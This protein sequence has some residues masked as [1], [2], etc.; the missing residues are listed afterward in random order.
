[1]TSSSTNQLQSFITLPKSIPSIYKKNLK[2]N[3][4]ILP[5][6]IA[7]MASICTLIE[8]D[9]YLIG[10]ADIIFYQKYCFS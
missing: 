5:F 7:L 3:I 8:N 6:K 10:K 4:F 9:T 2:T 1:M